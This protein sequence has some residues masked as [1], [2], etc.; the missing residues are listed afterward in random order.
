MTTVVS[1]PGEIR[2]VALFILWASFIYSMHITTQLFHSCYLF[3]FSD[4]LAEASTIDS[5]GGAYYFGIGGGI[6]N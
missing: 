4:P 6:D 1:M 5:A 2:E 3:H